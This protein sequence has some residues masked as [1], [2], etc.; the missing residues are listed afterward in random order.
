[1]MFQIAAVCTVDTTFVIKECWWDGFTVVS[2]SSH[3]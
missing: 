2:C 3:A 1:M